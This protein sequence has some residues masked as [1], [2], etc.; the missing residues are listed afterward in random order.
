MP[1]SRMNE[2]SSFRGMRRNRLPGTRNPFSVPLSKQRII[3]CW[4]T[5]QIFAASPVVNTVFVDMA[6]N[7]PSLTMVGPA[8]GGSQVVAA[9]NPPCVCHVE[10]SPKGPSE[11]G[12]GLGPHR[13]ARA[14]LSWFPVLINQPSA[15][16]TAQLCQVGK[17]LL[18]YQALA[19]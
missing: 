9:S 19:E 4:L 1:L 17:P 14:R 10:A 16:Q 2:Y 3:V 15:D 18:N 7:H 6:A 5:L 11:S 8:N 13:L 12:A